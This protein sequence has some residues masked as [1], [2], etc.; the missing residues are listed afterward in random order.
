MHQ[1]VSSG[2]I[3]LEEAEVWA[4]GKWV[5]AEIADSPPTPPRQLSPL[6][7]AFWATR[8]RGGLW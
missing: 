4:L 5:V 2:P 7:S 1:L 8:D 3:A 6:L